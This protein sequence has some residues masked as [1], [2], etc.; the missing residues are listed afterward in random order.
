MR[1]YESRKC[2][3]VYYGETNHNSEPPDFQIK[4][5]KSCE[6]PLTRQVTEAILIKNHVGDLLNSKSTADCPSEAG[7][8]ERAT[9]SAVAVLNWMISIKTNYLFL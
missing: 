6:E 1:Q 3:A 7:G 9:V 4:I 5:V 2:N 8:G